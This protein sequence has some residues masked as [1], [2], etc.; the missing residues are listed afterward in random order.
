MSRIRLGR[1]SF[2][3]FCERYIT[4]AYIRTCDKASREIHMCV[5]VWRRR[6]CLRS[7]HQTIIVLVETL[8]GTNVFMMCIHTCDL[9]ESMLIINHYVFFQLHKCRFNGFIRCH[10]SKNKKKARV[11]LRLRNFQFVSELLCKRPRVFVLNLCYFTTPN[12]QR[13]I[14]PFSRFLLAV[15]VTWRHEVQEQSSRQQHLTCP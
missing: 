9:Y 4:L 1:T 8:Q 12:F 2:T 6:E 15:A 10:Y 7:T 3:L 5:C 14:F 13:H 11:N